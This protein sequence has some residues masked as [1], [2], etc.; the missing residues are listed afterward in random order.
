MLSLIFLFQVSHHL[1]N[2]PKHLHP[3]RILDQLILR[4]RLGNV[5]D[6]FLEVLH[7]QRHIDFILHVLNV[8]DIETPTLQLSS[9]RHHGCFSA[10]IGDISSTITICDFDQLL[11]I[12]IFSGL[13]SSQIDLK[14]FFSSYCSWQGDV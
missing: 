12:N 13:Q 9:H 14:E 7:S 4:D 3:V 10:D 6:R 1:S 2:R 5:L 11:P 8:P